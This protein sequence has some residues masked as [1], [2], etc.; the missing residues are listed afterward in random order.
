MLFLS[1]IF[2]IFK[3][4]LKIKI[5]R[6]VYVIKNLEK[7]IQ[8]KEKRILAKRKEIL[9]RLRKDTP[10]FK[11]DFISALCMGLFLGISCILLTGFYG[12]PIDIK[13]EIMPQYL[14]EPE[15][16]KVFKWYKPL[17]YD[18]PYKTYV[19]KVQLVI[20]WVFNDIVDVYNCP[21]DGLAFGIS[22]D[23]Y[24]NP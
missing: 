19:G 6:I 13:V 23:I 21:I 10:I 12:D 14:P 24:F 15:Q 8:E 4:F 1:S 22:P 5:S 11:R 20:C 3:K 2:H 17:K 18:F 16:L 7:I 9:E